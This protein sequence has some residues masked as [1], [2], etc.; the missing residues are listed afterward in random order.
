MSA[1][2]DAI[3]IGGGL[4]GLV[5]ATY[6]AKAGRKVLLLEAEEILGGSCRASA[7]LPGVRASLGA[8]ALTA[9]DPRL[10]KDLGLRGLKFAARDLPTVA[11][12]PDGHHLVLGRDA[13]ASARAIAAQ[14]P[15]DAETYRR[16]RSEIF[17]LGR[18]MRPLWWDGLSDAFSDPLFSRLK[19]ASATAFLSNLESEPL[20]AAIAF[21]A[22]MPMQSGS[23]LALVW[24]AAQEMCGLQGAMAM[25]F[26]GVAALAD[27]LIIAAQAAG[28]EIRTK[29]RVAKILADSAVAGV[30][31]DTGEEIYSRAVLSSLSRRETLLDLSP[32]AAA[33]FSETARLERAAPLTGDAAI[34][35]LLNAAPDFGAPN[36]RFLIAE[37]LDAYA[38]AESIAREGRL[39]DELLIEAV[40]ATAA[41]PSLAPTGLHVLSVRVHGLP[42]APEGGSAEIIKR[43][44]AAL[45]RHTPHL[46]ERIIGLDIRLPYEQDVFSG[47]RLAA[48]YAERV[49]TPVEGLFL[50]GTGAEPMNA[51]SGRAG[52]LAAGIAQA[53]LAR[54][55]RA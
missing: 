20:K 27:M 21:D 2:S 24:R 4:N 51:I 35:F 7:A 14:S 22:G 54:E 36:G 38:A 8:H 47:E 52:R 40:V 26:G 18:A 53:W 42:L 43:V 33:G 46:R 50:C 29:A 3:V 30:S 17:A 55:K 28:I 5:A 44:I 49:E 37:R 45:E 39:P 9:L 1:R 13:H 32:T 34:L 10:V 11:L 6:L 41:D 31:L 16:M 12:R 19:V 23:A 25:P 48:A 15:A